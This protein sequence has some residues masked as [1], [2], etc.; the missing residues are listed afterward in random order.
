MPVWATFGQALVSSLFMCA[1]LC[2]RTEKSPLL[3]VLGWSEDLHIQTSR[4]PLQ[5]LG[6]HVM[7]LCCGYQEQAAA[8]TALQWHTANARKHSSGTAQDCQYSNFTA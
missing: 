3:E 6:V 5:L 2:M 1:A 8:I 4:A 7:Q